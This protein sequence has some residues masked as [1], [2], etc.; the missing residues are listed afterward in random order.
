MYSYS[1]EE[2]IKLI[3]E[4]DEDKLNEIELMTSCWITLEDIAN[5]FERCKFNG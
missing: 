4:A 1:K 3:N 2:L 5:A